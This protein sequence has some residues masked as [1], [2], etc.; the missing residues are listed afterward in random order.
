MI[1]DR[2]QI[3]ELYRKLR[4]PD[5]WP[6]WLVMLGIWLNRP[7]GVTRDYAAHRPWESVERYMTVLECDTWL[8]GA[9][10]WTVGTVGQ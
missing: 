10:Y 9:G 4:H 3:Q 5:G 2:A 8:A 1:L 6:D 7:F